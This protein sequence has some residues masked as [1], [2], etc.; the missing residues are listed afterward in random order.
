MYCYPSNRYSST[1][2]PLEKGTFESAQTSKMTFNS[3]HL[4]N[5]YLEDSMRLCMQGK[6]EWNR[7]WKNG[8]RKRDLERRLDDLVPIASMRIKMLLE[9]CMWINELMY[10]KSVWMCI[11]RN[12]IRHL[13][14][15]NT[16]VLRTSKGYI[17]STS[18]SKVHL[19][20]NRKH[21]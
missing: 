6:H 8:K 9:I 1:H 17:S 19:F 13:R 21:T 3:R 5:V 10:E 2:S 4:L 18:F 7:S 15:D 14:Y 20:H 11:P 12:H 16:L